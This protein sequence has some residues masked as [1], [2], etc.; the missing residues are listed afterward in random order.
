MHGMGFGPDPHSNS[1]GPVDCRAAAGFGTRSPRKENSQFT[2]LKF[3][4]PWLTVLQ[5]EDMFNPRLHHH[6]MMGAQVIVRIGNSRVSLVLLLV[7]CRRE[8]TICSQ[9][10][11]VQAIRGVCQCMIV[12]GLVMLATVRWKAKV[13]T[14]T[15]V[16]GL[17]FMARV[18]TQ[19][20]GCAL[21]GSTVDSC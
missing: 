12:W 4:I 14:C 2:L 8:G 18:S 3:A 21:L 17:L 20:L 1:K 6:R 5:G 16:L 15:W 10:L 13:Q 19:A 7:L 9:E 11:L